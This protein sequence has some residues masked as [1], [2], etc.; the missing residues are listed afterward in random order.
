MSTQEFIF[1]EFPEIEP[2]YNTEKV[3]K[4][5]GYF[6]SIDLP[7]YM[8]VNEEYISRIM[9]LLPRD[10]VYKFGPMNVSMFYT[11]LMIIFQW[12]TI[13]WIN[14]LFELL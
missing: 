13:N 14:K 9:R 5:I 4:E 2:A 1:S 11:I 10:W 6:D 7:L 8:Q 12:Y 3:S